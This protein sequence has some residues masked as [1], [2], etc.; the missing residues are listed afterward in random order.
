MSSRYVPDRGDIVWLNFSP[1]RGHEQG[2]R[3]P[4]IILS[5]LAYNQK[6]SLAILCPI[7]NWVKGYTFEVPLTQSMKTTGAVIATT[8][9]ILIGVQEKQFLLKKRRMN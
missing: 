6:T 3:R 1:H 4:A 7:T 8:L 9:K 5:P 2:F